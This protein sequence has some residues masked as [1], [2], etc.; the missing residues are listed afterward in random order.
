M[1]DSPTLVRRYRLFLLGLAA[2]MCVGAIIELILSKHYEDPAQL[3][4]FAL[5]GLGLV[6]LVAVLLRPVR[7]TL[8]ALRGVMALVI[9]GSLF[10]IWEHLESN[11][12]FELE[13]RPGSGVGDVWLQALQG[14]APLL[15]PGILAV[16]AI[17][18]IAATYAHPALE[19]APAEAAQQKLNTQNSKLKT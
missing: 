19:R 2:W 12:S 11:L 14:A 3:I 9:F 4:P 5:C 8:Y 7:A 15:A 18:A 16:A 6:V 17:I 1:L 10:G 13:M